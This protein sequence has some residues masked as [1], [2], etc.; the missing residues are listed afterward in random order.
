MVIKIDFCGEIKE[1]DII[2]KNFDEFKKID[3]NIFLNK[4][5]QHAMLVKLT[6]SCISIKN[7]KSEITRQSLKQ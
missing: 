4:M 7:C 1:T 6:R 3:K 5:E 2:P